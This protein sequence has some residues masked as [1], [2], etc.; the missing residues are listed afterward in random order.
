MFVWFTT[1]NSY[2][3][4]T[5]IVFHKQAQNIENRHIVQPVGEKNIQQW[6]TVERGVTLA[7]IL[8]VKKGHVHI[9][10]FS[11]GMSEDMLFIR[12]VKNGVM[13]LPVAER[14]R[15]HCRWC[16]VLQ[17]AGVESC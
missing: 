12:I 4:F 1:G 16:S 17:S 2:G 7:V 6:V 13:S 15:G 14:Q 10:I 11:Y 8:G 9:S 5:S 3:P